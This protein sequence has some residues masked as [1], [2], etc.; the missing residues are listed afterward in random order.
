MSFSET[1]IAQLLKA[2]PA[3]HSAGD[4]LYL[5]VRS[6]TSASWLFKFAWGGKSDEVGL[7]SLKKVTGDQARV[8][9]EWCLA[10][11]AAQPPRNPRVSRRAVK[12][13]IVRAVN[14]PKS[15]SIEVLIR[16]NVRMMREQ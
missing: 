13:E 7:G 12:H 3:K 15:K 16:E 14:A 11:L 5:D 6:P 2:A 4:G 9:R 1:K 10:E 8:L